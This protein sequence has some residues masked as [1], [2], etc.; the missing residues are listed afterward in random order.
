MWFNNTELSPQLKTED[1]NDVNDAMIMLH[2][3]EWLPCVAMRTRLILLRSFT[4]GCRAPMVGT[5]AS[6]RVSWESCTN[7]PFS[8]NAQ[9]GQGTQCVRSCVCVSDTPGLLVKRIVYSENVNI[10]KVP[11]R[12]QT[13]RHVYRDAPPCC[14]IPLQPRCCWLRFV[15]P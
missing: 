13:N 15:T 6:P 12:R 7:S 3:C 1:S 4:Q 14:K 8:N 5:G 2:D 9:S 10:V 11:W